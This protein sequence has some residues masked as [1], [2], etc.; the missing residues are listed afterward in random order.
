MIGSRWCNAVNSVFHHDDA[1]PRHTHP[2]HE[3]V[4]HPLCVYHERMGKAINPPIQEL[5]EPTM[6]VVGEDIVHRE[7]ESLRNCPPHGRLN[8]AGATPSKR[9]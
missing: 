7:H 4:A 5:V 3:F 9:E 6:C 2:G 1:V 8:K